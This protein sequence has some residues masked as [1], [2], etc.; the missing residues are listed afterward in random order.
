MPGQS[1]SLI[2]PAKAV[3]DIA[4]VTTGF[5]A[6][7]GVATSATTVLALMWLSVRIVNGIL[8]M[9]SKWR[10]DKR[11]RKDEELGKD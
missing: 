2:E 3:V 9:R 11:E 1:V 6:F 8:E 5:A 7:I 4:A 10:N